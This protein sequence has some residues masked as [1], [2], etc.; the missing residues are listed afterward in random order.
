MVD[1][2]G[3]DGQPLRVTAP[4]RVDQTAKL[5][6]LHREIADHPTN[7]LTPAKL[8]SVYRRAMEGD[9]VSQARLAM[10]MEEKDAHIFAEVSK[11]RIAVQSVKWHIEPPKDATPAEEEGTEVVRQIVDELDIDDLLHGMSDAVLHSYS[12]SE[13]HWRMVDGYNIPTQPEHRPP[14][15]F[16]TDHHG[17]QHNRLLL[18]DNSGT[19]QALRPLNWIAHI[20]RSRSAY[21][22]RAGLVRV[23]GWPFLM[24]AMAARDLAEFL[25][26]YGLPLRIGTYPTGASEQ[27]K[28]TLLRAVVGIGHA[29]AGIMPEGMNIEFKDAAKAGAGGSPFMDMMNWAEASISKAVLG[30]TLTSTA[31]ATGMGSGASDTHNEVRKE[32]STSDRRQ[33]GQTLERQLLRPIAALNTV[34]RRAPRWVWDDEEPA[35]MKAMSD[36]LPGLV[37][38]GLR[39]PAAWAHERLNIPQ[40]EAGE[41]ILTRQPTAAP[42]LGLMS[43]RTVRLGIPAA[44]T[45]TPGTASADAVQDQIK[46]AAAQAD[47]VVEGWAEQIRA[48]ANEAESLADL[49]ARIEAA[50]PDLQPNGMADAM[51][52]A[53]AAAHLAGRYDILEGV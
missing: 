17:N 27:E 51:G 36:S 5:G 8:A 33:H 3:I 37:D 16:T 28:S 19:G 52:D 29:A 15:W 12:C 45:Q 18:R 38:A 4:S 30:G 6:Q 23:L 20:Q 34:M 49:K 50:F 11:R 35:D 22:A 25:E 9:L 39:I 48:M 32:I 1:I 14:D 53:L 7:G 31:E 2:I 44:A 24:R 42:G 13:Y 26:I 21:L 47:H 41:E 43:Q 40:A 46:L 10:D